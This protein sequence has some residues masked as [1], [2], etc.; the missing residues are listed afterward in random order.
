MILYH[1]IDGYLWLCST[2]LTQEEIHLGFLRILREA[3][4]D[5]AVPAE[6][7]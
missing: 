7:R 1:M 5:I 2:Q 4:T 6:G 3:G